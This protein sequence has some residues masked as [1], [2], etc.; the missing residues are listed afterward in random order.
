MKTFYDDVAAALITV[1]YAI[2]SVSMLVV[3]IAGAV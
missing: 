1:T 3:V 2:A